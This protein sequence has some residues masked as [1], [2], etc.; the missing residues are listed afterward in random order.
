MLFHYIDDIKLTG[1]SE[2]EAA[3]TLNLL[4]R[5]FCVRRWEIIQL[6]FR[7]L[8]GVK[9]LEVQWYGISQY[10]FLRWRRSCIWSLLQPRKRHNAW[11]AS[12]DLG[13]NIFLLWVYYFSPFTEW[14][15]KLFWVQ[16]KRGEGPTA[17]PG[18][19]ASYSA[20]WA[21]RCRRPS[22]AWRSSQGSCWVDYTGDLPS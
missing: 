3:T 1:P 6:K 21:T 13:G 12:L 5:H 14:P 18:C 8:L 20:S 7:D 15:Q 11:Q 16:P 17:G 4:V 9:F 22:G 19:C 10:A 2:W